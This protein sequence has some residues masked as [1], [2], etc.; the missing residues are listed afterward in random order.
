MRRDQRAVGSRQR[1]KGGLVM[2]ARKVTKALQNKSRRLAAKKPRK[3]A[4]KNVKPLAARHVGNIKESR[5][6]D[7]PFIRSGSQFVRYATA[8]EIERINAMRNHPDATRSA[9]DEPALRKLGWAHKLNLML[10]IWTKRL[11][12]RQATLDHP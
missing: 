1:L 2:A 4:K 3:R 11:F 5:S 12:Q 9:S 8:S 6:V 10:C 7:P